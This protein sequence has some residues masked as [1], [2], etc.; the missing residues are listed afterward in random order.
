MRA[1]YLLFAIGASLGFASADLV[2]NQKALHNA[3]QVI[4][5][6]TNDGFKMSVKDLCSSHNGKNN[7]EQ[8]FGSIT[9]GLNRTCSDCTRN[10]FCAQQ[11]DFIIKECVVSQKLAGGTAQM[12]GMIAE[13][14]IDASLS[15]TAQAKAQD[16]RKMRIARMVKREAKKP[17]PPKP[18]TPPKQP[19]EKPKPEPKEKPKD[20]LTKESKKQKG[21]LK[22]SPTPKHT[23]TPTPTP[24]HKACS[25]KNKQGGKT[26]GKGKTLAKQDAPAKENA[27]EKKETPEKKGHQRRSVI[28]RLFARTGSDDE[29]PVGPSTQEEMTNAVP[30]TPSPPPKTPSPKGKGKGTPGSVSSDPEFEEAMRN[31]KTPS[32][33]KKGKRPANSPTGAS[34]ETKRPAQ[35]AAQESEECE[36]PFD[37]PMH[38]PWSGEVFFGYTTP[39]LEG[40]TPKPKDIQNIAKQGWDYII[41][42]KIRHSSILVVAAVYVPG[43]GVFLGTIPTPTGGAEAKFEQELQSYTLLATLL[44]NR[45]IKGG[46]S[47]YHAEDAA[48]W[49]AFEKGAVGANDRFPP[50][51]TMAV[52]GSRK[53]LGSPGEPMKPCGNKEDLITPTCQDVLI[54]MMG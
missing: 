46:T 16:F 51:S 18:P 17:K 26:H 15:E 28:S 19:E 44:G 49:Y 53:K 36:E 11:F 32:D 22:P 3:T 2:C 40:K 54:E 21:K 42:E 35:G 20:E 8:H 43:K 33:D 27:P 23:P 7:A 12:K 52:F 48:M 41:K 25:L 29:F 14:S 4:A 50:G 1:T 38:R 47:K 13:I 10:A 5:D 37:E 31:L 6:S 45:R 34:P 9:L 30:K 24:K 39:T